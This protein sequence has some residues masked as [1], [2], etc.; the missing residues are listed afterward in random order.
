MRTSLHHLGS[1]TRSRPFIAWL[2]VFALLVA[3]TAYLAHIHA[4]ADD[5]DHGHC[6]LCL[7]LTGTAGAPAPAAPC[8]LPVRRS[9]RVRP[10]GASDT[11]FPHSPLRSH[12]SRAPPAQVI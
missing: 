5:L 7:Q 4:A 11:L 6:K 9:E 8:S 1:R 12:R 3:S 10:P 2:A